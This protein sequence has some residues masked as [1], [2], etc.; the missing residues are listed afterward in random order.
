MTMIA[1]AAAKSSPGT[2]TV[3]ELLA[4][5]ADSVRRRVL[6]DCDPAGGDWL[7]RPGVTPEPGLASLAMAGRRGLAAM[8]VLNHVQLLGDGLEV[9]VAPAAARQAS[10][11]LD[12]IA[13]QLVAHLRD[14]DADAIV[15]CGGLTPSSP[16]LPL[17]Q[18]ADAVVLVARPTASAMV[19]VAPWVEQLTTGGARV[20]VVL[21]E[22]GHRP[23]EL[24]YRPAEVAEALGVEV[25]GPVADDPATSAAL[26]AA[27]GRLSRFTRSRLVRSMVPVAAAVFAATASTVRPTATAVQ[28]LG[29]ALPVSVGARPAWPWQSHADNPE[30]RRP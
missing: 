26:Y 8:E 1:V 21:V 30:A 9:V 23:A 14:V 28:P 3:A 10:S 6:I 12:I 7:L 5:L 20:V 13:N 17:A 29:D 22:H 19:H 2:S 25:L 27:P 11:A 15:D 4:Q 18:A 16:A 24:A